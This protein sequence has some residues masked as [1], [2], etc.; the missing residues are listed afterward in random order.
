M[1]KENYYIDYDEYNEELFFLIFLY[2][3]E[4]DKKPRY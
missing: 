3:I 1:V 2:R 4:T